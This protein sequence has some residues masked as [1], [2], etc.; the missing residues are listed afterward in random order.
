MAC[1]PR[2]MQ[3]WA[4]RIHTVDVQSAQ[5]SHHAEAKSKSVTDADGMGIE[6]P[7]DA[8]RF[9]DHLVTTMGGGGV[10]LPQ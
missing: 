1:V 3:S 5:P 8:R 10:E 9:F 6:Y 4:I 2:M 7:I